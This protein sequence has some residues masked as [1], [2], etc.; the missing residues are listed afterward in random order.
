MR[1]VRGAKRP[2]TSRRACGPGSVRRR[3]APTAGRSW[4]CSRP[5]PARSIQTDPTPSP[6]TP[7]TP[8]PSTRFVPPAMPQGGRVPAPESVVD[9]PGG[10]SVEAIEP[11]DGPGADVVATTGRARVIAIANQ[12]GGVG[13][14]TTAVNLGAALAEAGHQVLVVDLDPQGNASTGMGID[15]SNRQ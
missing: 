4:P 5:I 8:F 1:A 14:S 15:H 9:A 3:G 2:R 12:K 7:A 10:A 11:E 6:E 13:K